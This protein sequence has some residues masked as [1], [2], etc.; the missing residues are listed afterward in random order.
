M[1]TNHFKFYY[2]LLPLFLINACGKAAKDRNNPG[3]FA[4]NSFTPVNNTDHFL[5]NS[6]INNDLDTFRDVVSQNQLDLKEIIIE[7]ETAL[8]TAIISDSI[9]VRD[10]LLERGVDV[11]ETNTNGQTPLMVAVTH[12]RIGSVRALLRKKPAI[13]KKNNMGDTALIISIKMRHEE[14]AL[15]LIHNGA[16]INITDYH[17]STAF[18]LAVEARLTTLEETLRKMIQLAV[19][20]PD[21]HSFRDAIVSGDVSTIRTM[22]MK[23]PGL[24]NSYEMINPLDLTMAV[25]NE[26]IGLEIARSLLNNNTNVNGAQNADFSPLIRAVI[27]QKKSFVELLLNFKANTQLLDRIGRSPLIHAIEQ[28]SL[29]M[30][31]MLLSRSAVKKYNFRISSDKTISIDSCKVVKD[32]RKTLDREGKKINKDIKK[33]L[34]CG[35]WDRLF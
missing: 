10:Y 26:S 30:V 27:L 5:K 11:N 12:N 14:I 2:I 4:E 17:N 16:N 1:K 22:L 20:T 21:I 33:R 35:L 19:G 18:E 29:E 28:N 13:D 15:L 3:L 23:F 9:E 32:V 6:I 24:G 8:T 31:E 25:E 7:G 34:S